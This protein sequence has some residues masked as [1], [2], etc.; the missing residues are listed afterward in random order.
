MKVLIKGAGD[1]ATGVAV[2][3]H[4]C[5]FKILMTEIDFPTTVRRTVAFSS[6][7]F[8]GEI[9]VENINAKLIKSFAEI[10]KTHK[11]QEIPVIIDPNCECLEFYKP[12]VIIDAIL[13]K[14]NIN[15][16]KTQANIVIALGPGFEADVDCDI[17]IETNRG[18]NLGRCIYQGFAEK[19]TGI[20][21]SINGFSSERILR[22]SETG[23]VLHSAK[24]G[25][26]VTKNQEIATINGQKVIAEI[27]GM[28]RGLIKEGCY[29]KK[30]LKI[31]DIDPRGDFASYTTVSD[32]ARAIAGGVLEGILKLSGGI[33]G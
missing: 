13:A 24:I 15:T 1:L 3:L 23:K 31:G 16:T 30:G 27:D 5:G 9:N 32:K 19:N 20:P 2:R 25:D 28:I 21:G 14:K 4:N 7:V 11:N 22:A 18:H 6:A 29:V 17:V 8:D 10:E 26:I 33:N 12:D